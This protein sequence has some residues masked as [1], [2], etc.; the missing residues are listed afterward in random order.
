MLFLSQLQPRVNF[1]NYVRSTGSW[2]PRTIPDH[3]IIFVISGSAELTLGVHSYV[4]EAGDCVYYGNDS[5]HQI[6]SS[7]TEGIA[8]YSIH[9]SWNEGADSPFP[10]LPHLG[11]RNC[12]EDMLQIPPLPSKVNVENYGEVLLPHH[13]SCPEARNLFAEIVQEYKQ[14]EPGY[15]AH[16]G[17][18]LKQIMVLIVRKAVN[19][20]ATLSQRK[21]IEPALKAILE[22]P[23]EAWTT[24]WLASLCGYH[25]TYF[26]EQFKLVTGYSPNRYLNMEKIRTAKRHLTNGAGS[27]GSIAELLGFANIHYFSRWFKLAT[28]LT[29]SEY[30]GKNPL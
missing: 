7:K 23:L 1:A 29:P 8:F 4:M 14:E 9:F 11:L 19:G 27:I 26:A 17:S 5:P 12:S 3:Q 28:G 24:P 25:P 22:Q 15:L 6:V 2:G 21:K 18:L 13:V 30:R 20:R 10:V 16:I